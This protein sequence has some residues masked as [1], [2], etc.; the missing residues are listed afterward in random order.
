MLLKIQCCLLQ[1][2]QGSTI[3]NVL[4][5]ICKR[6]RNGISILIFLLVAGVRLHIWQYLFKGHL[7][8][9]YVYFYG[10]IFRQ[11]LVLA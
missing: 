3:K 2:C 8:F 6:K 5:S 10:E 11:F 7:N 9:L 4:T 1:R